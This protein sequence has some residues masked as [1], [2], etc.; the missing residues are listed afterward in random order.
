[1][2]PN[3]YAPPPPG[4]ASNTPG[5]SSEPSPEPTAGA[6]PVVCEHGLDNAAYDY[7]SGH[8]VMRCELDG[9]AYP[10]PPVTQSGW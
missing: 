2:M 8:L 9:T 7:S 3:P 1:M 10:V 4:T 6:A 5:P